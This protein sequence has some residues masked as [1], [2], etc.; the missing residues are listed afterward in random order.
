MKVRWFFIK[1]NMIIFT[2]IFIALI[3]I[4]FV[5]YSNSISILAE[6]FSNKIPRKIDSLKTSTFIILILVI[7]SNILP[8]EFFNERR[9]YQLLESIQTITLFLCICLN[10]K[11]R[12]IFIRVS[13]TFTFFIRQFFLFFIFYEEVSFLSVRIN[14]LFLKKNFGLHNFQ[15]EFNFHNNMIFQSKLLSLT[16][17]TTDI[18]FF[19]TT[20]N[21]IY[22]LILFFIGY[23]SYFS[24][25][26]GIKHFFLDRNY[27]NFTLI[28]IADFI[29]DDFG[30]NIIKG[31]LAET[32]IYLL[33]LLDIL[34][35]RKLCFYAPKNNNKGTKLF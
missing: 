23:G 6:S 28:V 9:E 21:L 16:V 12:K 25:F 31:E 20:D 8:V 14:M 5:F 22:S 19:I 30:I 15:Q 13:N 17:P 7:F 4:V 32:F 29:L 24:F 3:S 35:K 10:L 11:F 33:F 34:T 26:K 1:K 18:T 2:L 27:A